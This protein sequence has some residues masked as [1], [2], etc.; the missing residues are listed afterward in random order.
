MPQGTAAHYMADTM[1]L[2]TVSDLPSPATAGRLENGI[3][4]AP[5]L[6]VLPPH[7]GDAL[8]GCPWQQE[9]CPPFC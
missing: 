3:P 9:T 2:G 5:G 6:N 1:C 4:L 8:L 7:H